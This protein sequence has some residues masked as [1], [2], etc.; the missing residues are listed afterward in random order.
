MQWVADAVSSL[1]SSGEAQAECQR[2]ERE[3]LQRDGVL[4]KEQLR[5]FFAAGYKMFDSEDVKANLKEA[6][7]KR[8]DVGFVV[9]ELQKEI[10]DSL[11]IDGKYGISFLGKIREKYGDDADFMNELMT[12]V[13]REE[14]ALDEAELPDDKLAKKLEMRQLAMQQMTS[15]REQLRH[16][17][18]E[19]QVQFMRGQSAM[20]KEM[21]VQ[22][23]EMFE[24]AEAMSPEERKK[25]IEEQMAVVKKRFGEFKAGASIPPSCSGHGH[26]SARVEPSMGSAMSTEE[27]MNF[28]RSLSKAK[29]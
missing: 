28:F 19:E 17:S 25:F 7:R 23:K 9:T 12:F 16:M 26:P 10:F 1:F 20:I 4:T 14:L 8:Q 11:G 15:M 24:K 6:A 2:A 5:K 21:N 29:Q 3:G 18:P 27:Q 13:D 22:H